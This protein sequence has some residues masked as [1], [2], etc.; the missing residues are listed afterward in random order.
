MASNPFLMPHGRRRG[1][2]A[3]QFPYERTLEVRLD[4]YCG[5]EQ[6]DNL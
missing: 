5:Y 4:E 3:V 6:S 2:Q 1:Q